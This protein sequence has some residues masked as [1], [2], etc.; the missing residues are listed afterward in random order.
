MSRPAAKRKSSKAPAAAATASAST[1]SKRAKPSSSPAVVPLFIV[2]EVHEEG[3][4][5]F[6]DASGVNARRCLVGVYSTALEANRAAV[7]RFYASMRRED[8]PDMDNEDEADVRCAEKGPHALLKLEIEH[9]EE[10]RYTLTVHVT[11]HSLNAG[12]SSMTKQEYSDR[13]VTLRRRSKATSASVDNDDEE[14]E[15][16]DR[17]EDKHDDEDED[18]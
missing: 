15:E 11:E 13:L 4:S 3:W 1:S 5:G 14:I 7:E 18:S 9:G 16:R 8:F 10:S 6:G 2:S 17:D 12:Q